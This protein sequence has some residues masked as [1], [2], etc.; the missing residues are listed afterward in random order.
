MVQRE[1]SAV[2]YK[3]LF[4]AMVRHISLSKTQQTNFIHVAV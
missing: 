1:N 3:K 4:G 2:P